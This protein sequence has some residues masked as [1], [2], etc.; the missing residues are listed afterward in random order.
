MSVAVERDNE[1]TAA[2]ASEVEIAAED[3]EGTPE[4]ATIAMTREH[5]A[6]IVI[7]IAADRRGG[8]I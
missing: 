2:T 1:V 6:D 3:V 4:T 8:T 7:G 5:T